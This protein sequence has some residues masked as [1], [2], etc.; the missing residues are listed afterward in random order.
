MEAEQILKQL[1]WLDEERRKDKTRLSAIEERLTAVD[2][3]IPPLAHQ[4]KD[5]SSEVTRLET[6]IARMD[7]FDEMLVQQRIEAKQYFEELER[8]IK[9]REEEGEKVRRVELRAVDQTLADLRKELEPIAEIKR[10]LKAR[11][12]EESRLARL[13]DELRTKIDAS[14]RSEEEYTR[15]FRLVDDGRRQDAKRMTDMQGEM[16]AVRKRVDEQ[17]GR[18]ELVATSTKKIETRLN[19]L[20][21]VETERRETLENFLEKQA[22]YQVE[23]ERVWKEWEA[24]FAVIE[25]QTADVDANLQ[26]LD[27]THRAVKR[28]QQVVEEITQK[29]ERRINEITEIQRLAEERFRQEWVTFKADDQKRWTNYTLT[30]EEQRNDSVRQYERITERVGSIEDSIQEI[31]DILQQMTEQTEKRL[32]SLLTV[33]HEWATSYERSVGRPR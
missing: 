27:A 9:K 10:S 4:I 25:S 15:T 19:E 17:R 22:L 30:I 1:D 20:N 12:D 28:T 3:N 16:A 31:Q 33:A 24:R 23:R 8:Q 13:I 21:T 26:T 11:V 7:H 32:Q 29:I 14:R 2:G 6:I 18:L 5:L